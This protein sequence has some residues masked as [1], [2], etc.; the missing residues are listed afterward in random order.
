M[1]TFSF[2]TAT[3]TAKQARGA[4]KKKK[5]KQAD[6]VNEDEVNEDEVKH[7]D[8]EYSV[9]SNDAEHDAEDVAED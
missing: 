9:L 3:T 8:E 6:E 7:V 4:A 5:I 1:P 2:P